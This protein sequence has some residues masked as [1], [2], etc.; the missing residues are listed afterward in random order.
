MTY[1]RQGRRVEFD[2]E[3]VFTTTVAL[4]NECTRD[5]PTG[6]AEA[7]IVVTGQA[8]SLVLLGRRGDPIGPGVSWLDER[9]AGEAAEI[10]EHFGADAAFAVT[11][12]PESV[13][14]W[15]ASKLL[16]VARHDPRLRD[17]TTHVLM[18]K[19]YILFRFTGAVVG[20]LTTRGFTYLFDVPGRRY[21]DAMLDFC[22]VDRA[23]LPEIVP[24]GT[25][26][27]DVLPAVEALLPPAASYRVNTGALDHFCAM[28]GTDSYRPGA[29]SASAGT[30]LSLSMLPQSW[31]F[32]PSMKLSFHAG[33]RSDETVLFTCADSGGASLTWWESVL[34]GVD[35]RE[36]ESVLTER[37][38][39]TAP[40]FL[41]Y[42]TGLN[43]PDFNPAAR[44]AFVDLGIEHDRFDLIFAVM[45]GVAHLLRRNLDDLATHGH[46]AEEIVSAG[47]GTVS[48]FWN[49]L[50]AD[51]CQVELRTP[52]EPEASCRGAAILALAA[53]GRIGSLEDT[54]HLYQPEVHSYRPRASE[55]LR[56]R[57]LAFENA[58]HRL[59]GN[60]HG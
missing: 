17:A 48:T 42:L 37:D 15:P 11:G 50:K 27:G 14:T 36:V 31:T 45:E 29:L 33:I 32:D 39:R 60:A 58:L 56:T 7:C 20:E 41:P 1:L 26:I 16:W 22:Q 2:A 46:Q 19:D 12:E 6:E 13:S 59:Y 44:G 8:E 51:T 9:S 55:T 10:A 28:V 54:G 3:E 30:V 35:F 4:I 49:Q 5:Q 40:V 52:R 38:T 24:A 57:H 21:W 47:G 23:H 25:D 18:L 43:P 34:G 53:S